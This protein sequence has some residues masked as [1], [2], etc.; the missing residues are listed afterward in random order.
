MTYEEEQVF[1]EQAFVPW[2]EFYQELIKNNKK[3]GVAIGPLKVYV[4]ELEYDFVRS[5]SP[6]GFWFCN[7]Q[8]ANGYIEFVKQPRIT[9]TVDLERF[10]GADNA[11]LLLEK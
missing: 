8:H 9:V 4:G 10:I 1:V 5:G 3:M 2:I 7:Y 6:P 11:N